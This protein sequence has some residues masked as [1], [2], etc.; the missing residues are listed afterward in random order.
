[1]SDQAIE[2]ICEAVLIVLLVGSILY[3][4]TRNR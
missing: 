3:I 1:V 2:A 4:E